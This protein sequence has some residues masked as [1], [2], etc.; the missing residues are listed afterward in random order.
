MNK[1]VGS[2]LI[3]ALLVVALLT[4][5]ISL[6]AISTQAFKN[7]TSSI[8]QYDLKSSLLDYGKTLGIKFLYEHDK[9]LY[10]L[11]NNGLIA[12]FNKKFKNF[13]NIDTEITVQIFDLQ[14]KI[15][16]NN[17]MDPLFFSMFLNYIKQIS[18]LEF[19]KIY[20]LEIYNWISKGFV[21][22]TNKKSLYRSD[23]EIIK[24]TQKF[25]FKYNNNFP[26]YIAA[27]QPCYDI[28]ELRLL[29]F[30]KPDITN[31]F[32][33]N[34]IAVPAYTPLNVLT[35]PIEIIKISNNN[36]SESIL[37]QLMQYRSN[38]QFAAIKLWLNKIYGMGVRNEQL[39]IGS[40]YYLIKS[41][42]TYKNQS[43]TE[44]TVINIER[45]NNLQTPKFLY[46]IITKYIQ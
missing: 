6:S 44:N 22:N 35:T 3:T 37:Q 36:L 25:D 27:H 21:V 17:I 19:K 43:I 9:P 29:S 16:I 8:V 20:M 46:K 26:P 15:N 12:E 41:N 13:Q 40:N 28:S 31:L 34:F 32:A 10:A 33:N 5:L 30:M 4:A 7:Y 39:A 2:A 14:S 24:K 11:N 45:I 18:D 23:S 38:H 42:L 1:Q